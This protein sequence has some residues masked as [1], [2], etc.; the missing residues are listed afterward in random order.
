[1]PVRIAQSDANDI[2][3]SRFARVSRLSWLRASSG[4]PSRNPVMCSPD[5]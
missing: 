5:T 4:R 2:A 1:M 3:R